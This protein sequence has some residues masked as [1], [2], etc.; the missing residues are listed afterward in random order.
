M[1][2]FDISG[3]FQI[4]LQRVLVSYP[5]CVIVM[6]VNFPV[7]HLQTVITSVEFAV[8][9]KLRQQ[10]RDVDCKADCKAVGRNKFR[11]NQQKCYFC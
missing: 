3:S 10:R 4:R 5:N 2:D 7:G 8:G 9:S 6:V 1:F 11:I